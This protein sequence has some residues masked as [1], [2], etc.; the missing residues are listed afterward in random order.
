MIH[1]LL[2]VPLHWSFQFV[3]NEYL[4][5]HSTVQLEHVFWAPQ[6]ICSIVLCY[7][8][9]QMLAKLLYTSAALLSPMETS[10]YC[11]HLESK[12]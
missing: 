9:S 7:S 1:T 6:A 2:M 3:L 11:A 12:K 4:S 10:I 5:K 8:L